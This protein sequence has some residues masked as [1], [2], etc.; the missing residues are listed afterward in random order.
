MLNQ[1]F[2]AVCH[3]QGTLMM[4][5]SRKRLNISEPLHFDKKNKEVLTMRE[6]LQKD[7]DIFL[8]P[9]KLNYKKDG[10]YTFLTNTTVSSSVAS[11]TST[12]IVVH[13]VSTISTILTRI[14]S[15]IIHT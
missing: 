3:H 13:T 12:V 2:S 9:I 1:T 5:K 8:L 6:M 14:I 4:A 11:S 7:N 15:A 10:K